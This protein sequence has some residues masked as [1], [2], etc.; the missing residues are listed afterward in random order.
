MYI[1]L[2][3]IRLW[4]R[5]ACL[6]NYQERHFLSYS[7]FPLNWKSWMRLARKFFLALITPWILTPSQWYPCNICKSRTFSIFAYS[8][9]H[10]FCILRDTCFKK[11]INEERATDKS[12]VLQESDVYH[13]MKSAFELNVFASMFSCTWWNTNLFMWHVVK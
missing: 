13:C 9:L 1:V 6:W 8:F 7:L 2:N 11:T 5:V 12:M 4:R 3:E 10:L